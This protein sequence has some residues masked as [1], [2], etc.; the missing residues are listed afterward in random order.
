MEE[1]DYFGKNNVPAA[2]NFPNVTSA[3]FE[4]DIANGGANSEPLT[5]GEK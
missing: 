4:S 5:V 2:L 1:T 3:I